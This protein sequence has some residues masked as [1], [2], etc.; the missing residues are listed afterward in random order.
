MRLAVL[1]R[2]WAERLAPFR[3]IA[4]SAAVLIACVLWLVGTSPALLGRLGS[5]FFALAGLAMLG[6]I[7][8]WG[9]FL[10]TAWFGP[11]R[12]DT[13]YRRVLETLG[14]WLLTIWF[15]LGTVGAV[16]GILSLR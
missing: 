11:R 13:P 10:V 3:W 12:V 7:W 5:A 2:Q 1:Y 6:M 14:A 9:V 8:T 4:F 15:V 16:W